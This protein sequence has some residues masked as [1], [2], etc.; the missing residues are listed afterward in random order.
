VTS[1]GV[2]RVTGYKRGPLI[3]AIVF[4][5]LLV[6]AIVGI[7]AATFFLFRPV[8]VPGQAVDIGSLLF[9]QLPWLV[10]SVGSACVGAYTRLR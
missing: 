8:G 1:E 5:G 9:G 4:G 10:I 3:L 7:S 6:G 2:I